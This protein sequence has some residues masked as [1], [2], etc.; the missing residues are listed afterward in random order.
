MVERGWSGWWSEVVASDRDAGGA[1]V[2][3]VAYRICP[4]FRN[5]LLRSDELSA[6]AERAAT[7]ARA[8]SERPSK[9]RTV[10]A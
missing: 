6:R 10:S 5:I 3:V 1:V 2:V 8:I 7:R 9:F 4:N